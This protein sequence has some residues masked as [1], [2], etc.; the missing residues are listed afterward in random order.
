MLSTLLNNIVA[1]FSKSF[2]IAS[3]LPVL[4]FVFMNGLFAYLFFD[5]WRAWC[6]ANLVHY[7]EGSQLIFLIGA[8]VVLLI[9]MSYLVSSM[10]NFMRQLMEG[11][12]SNLLTSLFAPAQGKRLLRIEEKRSQASELSLRLDDCAKQRVAVVSA[13]RENST[14]EEYSGDPS[15]EKTIDL[16]KRLRAQNRLLDADK[17]EGALLR[18]NELLETYRLNG[19]AL[20]RRSLNV[21]NEELHDLI[22]FGREQATLEYLRFTNLRDSSFGTYLA[23]TRMGNIAASVQSSIERRYACDLNSVLS[24]LIVCVQQG[25]RKDTTLQ[26]AKVQLDFLIVSSFLTGCWTVVWMAVLFWFHSRAWFVIVALGGPVLTYCWYLAAAEQYRAF[27]DVLST[28]FDIYRFDL[29]KA[30][31]MPIPVDVD[32]ERLIWP[33]LDKLADTQG[34]ER[35]NFR[36]V[37]PVA[38]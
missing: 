21:C 4:T 23:P 18:F 32:E 2:L 30:L 15:L 9:V 10:S 13:E 25:E 6:N 27:N 35:I 5:P 17:L 24:N 28:V 3:F 1:A 31:H 36:Y 12:W 11:H 7:S 33:Q 38:K 26:D 16:L 19:H 34:G 20:V 29:L 22:Q 8:L 37:V 14:D